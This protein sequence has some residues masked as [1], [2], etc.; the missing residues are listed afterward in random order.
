[1]RNMQ[2]ANNKPVPPKMADLESAGTDRPGDASRTSDSPHAPKIVLGDEEIQVR[3][4]VDL[5]EW[6]K[7]EP[8]AAENNQ[9]GANRGG[10]GARR[11]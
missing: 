6:V 5:V 10:N 3:L 1:V 7:G 2:I 4:R 9:Q 8:V 11:N